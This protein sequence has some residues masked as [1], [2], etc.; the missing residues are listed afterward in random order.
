[1]TVVGEA[2]DGA[3]AVFLAQQ[4]RPD[5]VLMDVQMPGVD[6]ITAT[7]EI[8]R[9]LEGTSVVVLSLYDDVHTRAKAKAA[10]AAAFVAKQHMDSGLVDALRSCCKARPAAAKRP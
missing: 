3:S 10:G 2:A 7:S 9:R 1:G 4:L 6:G 5:V 8:C